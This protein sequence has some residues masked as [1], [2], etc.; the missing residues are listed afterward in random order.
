MDPISSAA[1]VLAMVGAAQDGVKISLKFLRTIKK[2]PRGLQALLDEVKQIEA[3]LSDVKHACEYGQKSTVALD[4]LLNKAAA[5][6]LELEEL[7]H[8]KLVKAKEGLEVDRLSFARYQGEIAELKDDL[9][10]LRHD[11][12]AVLSAAG[13]AQ[14]NQMKADLS[15]LSLATTSR[16]T[17]HA[18]TIE[19]LSSVQHAVQALFL[20]IEDSQETQRALTSMLGEFRTETA[21]HTA[22]HPT[23]STA[24]SNATNLQRSKLQQ[25][26]NP[27]PTTTQLNTNM[28][29]ETVTT[30]SFNLEHP[31]SVLGGSQDHSP[32]RQRFHTR[33][34]KFVGQACPAACPCPCHRKTLLSTPWVTRTLVGKLSITYTGLS[35]LSTACTVKSCRRSL[36]SSISISYALPAWVANRMLS[37]WYKSAP[38]T[39][40]ELLLKT[41]RII[42]TNSYFWVQSGDLEVLRSMY[43]RG[44]ASVHDV[45]TLFGENALAIAVRCRQLNVA[46]FLLNSGADVNCESYAGLTPIDQLLEFVLC[47]LEPESCEA[48]DWLAI[49]GLE[50][51]DFYGAL[52]CL[53][54]IVLGF[55]TRELP[56]ELLEHPESIDN[57]DQFGRTA[58]WWST[59]KGLDSCSELLLAHGADPNISDQE[60]FSPLHNSAGF[61]HSQTLALL[62]DRGAKIKPNLYGG[63]PIHFACDFNETNENLK[64]L[65]QW[66]CDPNV[67]DVSHKTPLH[68]CSLHNGD[69]NARV[70]LQSGANA[71]L[72][73][74]RGW[75]PWQSA[76][77]HNADKTLSLLLR[78]GNDLSSC[79]SQRYTALHLVSRYA[80]Q[81]IVDILNK[82]DLTRVD[83]D[84]VDQFGWTAEDYLENCLRTDHLERPG[85]SLDLHESIQRLIN[86]ARAANRQIREVSDAEESTSEYES[87]DAEDDDS[88]ERESSDDGYPS[89]EDALEAWETE[90]S[91]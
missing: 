3:V 70:L 75:Q 28:G 38:I 90:G 32:R 13:L 48:S 83:A 45:N 18:I 26:P 53:H 58:L 25:E 41:R 66:G 42:E 86:K 56:N 21:V 69:R 24:T 79:T 78:H 60:G 37:V 11:I 19:T 73:D 17:E 39:G 23:M 71:N 91:S 30:A 5:K 68:W 61:G 55:S 8:F 40:P 20:R 1:S 81:P 65:L 4:L 89:Y 9:K 47:R 27:V 64:L 85:C 43:I 22:T 84:A 35:L 12:T 7:I 74:E 15:Q 76:I 33:A 44:Q 46:R 62:Y 31:R 87:E 36:M 52:P 63:W 77:V 80:L 82:A 49:F 10:A 34:L 72:V 59:R 51:E 6:L 57:T 67:Q 2:A 29:T 88:L 50:F 54:R 16:V 14:V